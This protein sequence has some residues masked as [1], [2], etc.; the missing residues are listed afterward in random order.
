MEVMH[1]A[2]CST[3]VFAKPEACQAA[4]IKG[5][6]TNLDSTFIILLNQVLCGS[7]LL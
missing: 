1:A 5:P 3:D 2:E 4:A 6:E 7:E